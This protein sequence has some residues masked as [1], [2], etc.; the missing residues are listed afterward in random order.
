MSVRVTTGIGRSILACRVQF[1]EAGPY[2]ESGV[3][4]LHLLNIKICMLS[5]MKFV[6]A[7]RA[8]LIRAF[9]IAGIAGMPRVCISPRPTTVWGRG[10]ADAPQVMLHF[11]LDVF[12]CF[13]G[14][15]LGLGMA[16]FADVR[17]L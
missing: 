8:A 6:W 4:K 11:L 3:S 1:F 14:L 2:D 13:G 9:S 12:A 15:L 17:R 7:C 10:R 5:V 16:I